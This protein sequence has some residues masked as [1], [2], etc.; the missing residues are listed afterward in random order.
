MTSKVQQLRLEEN[1]GHM[2]SICCSVSF[3]MC[4]DG[5]DLGKIVTAFNVLSQV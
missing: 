2:P 1:Q 3:V 4:T 5:V